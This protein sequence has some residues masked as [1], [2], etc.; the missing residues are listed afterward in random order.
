M[1]LVGSWLIRVSTVFYNILDS[2]RSKN[3]TSKKKLLYDLLQVAENSGL[4]KDDA[5][6]VAEFI[7][8]H[9]FHL[10]IDTLATQLYEYD[11]TS[12]AAFLQEL[13]LVCDKIDFP[14][15]EIDYLFKEH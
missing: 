13:K 9:E 10:A 14:V 15:S 5:R 2:L 12:S 7:E 4:R 11:I 1:L 6:N 3:L 8:H